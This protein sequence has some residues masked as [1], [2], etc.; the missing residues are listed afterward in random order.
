MPAN[1]IFGRFLAWHAECIPP[2]AT[3]W[4]LQLI[5]EGNA[6]NSFNELEEQIK[7]RLAAHQE[8]CLRQY[9]HHVEVM[10]EIEGRHRRY[11]A[12]ADHLV[13]D[14]IRPR[15][16]T[17]VRHFDN[18]DLANVDASN[19]HQS[20]CT[21]KRTSRFP[22]NTKL[23][24][25]VS[26][27]GQWENL[28]LL[29]RLSIIPVFFQFDGQDQTILPLDRVDDEHVAKWTEGK[30]AKFLDAYLRLETLNEYQADNLV[31]D[32][33]CNMRINRAYAP[34]QVQYRGETHYFCL[35]VCREK[36]LEDPERYLVAQH[37]LANAVGSGQGN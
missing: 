5:R 10:H 6:M 31:T 25:S 37:A 19:R 12:I 28:W 9:N 21:F 27:D 36:F 1:L 26:R 22:A 23:E 4:A 11:E 32:P 3:R 2:W 14:V 8:L 33:V 29:Y 30:I 18:A 20:L 16:E 13:Q 17:L 7:K 35:P 34:A 24:L 15:L